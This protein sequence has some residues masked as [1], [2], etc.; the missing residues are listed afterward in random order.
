MD[1]K[2]VLWGWILVTLFFVACSSKKSNTI[3]DDAFHESF[4]ENAKTMNKQCPVQVDE[5]TTIAEAIASGKTLMIKTII[6]DDFIEQVDFNEFKKKM[7]QNFASSLEED[8]IK[9]MDDKGYSVKY[10]IYDEQDNL[11]TSIEIMGKNM[12][13]CLSQET[14]EDKELNEFEAK[15]MA[16]F[17]RVQKQLPIMYEDK[18][19][20]KT[21]IEQHEVKYI[22]RYNIIYQDGYKIPQEELNNFKANTIAALKTESM[23]LL[24]KFL[25]KNDLKI[26]TEFV[27]ANIIPIGRYEITYL[28]LI[29]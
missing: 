2:F 13:D 15:F 22:Y 9:Y 12:L 20:Y 3:S 11:K 14:S 8:F 28:D 29:E 21:S 7:T 6:K 1:R 19:L 16:D 17:K 23:E 5:I 26:V 24:P 4:I 18:Q 25:K 27:D 10:M